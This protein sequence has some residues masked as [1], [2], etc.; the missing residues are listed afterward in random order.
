MKKGDKAMG[1]WGAILVPMIVSGF[2][3]RF[4]G[5]VKG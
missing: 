3:M 1:I 5:E 2:S 4:E